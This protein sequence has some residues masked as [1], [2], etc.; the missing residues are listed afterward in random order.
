MPSPM[1]P[2]SIGLTWISRSFSSSVRTKAPVPLAAHRTMPEPDDAYSESRNSFTV[3]MTES[4][5]RTYRIRPAPALAD[6][7]HNESRN[8]LVVDGTPVL[9]GMYP[10][11]SAPFP[12]VAASARSDRRSWSSEA[13]MFPFFSLE[14]MANPYGFEM[15]DHAGHCLCQSTAYVSAVRYRT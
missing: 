8:A 1:A 13:G 10:T 7:D 5:G 4:D 6:V 12:V 11:R 14:V 9:G 15:I 3:V 2:K